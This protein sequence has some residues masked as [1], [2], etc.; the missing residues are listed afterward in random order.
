[1]QKFLL[2]LSLFL[3]ILLLVYIFY[4]SRLAEKGYFFI[5]ELKNLMNQSKTMR[6]SMRELQQPNNA[7]ITESYA[8]I[9]ETSDIKEENPDTNDNLETL[10]KK[11][12]TRIQQQLNDAE[13]KELLEALAQKQLSIK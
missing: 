10:F 5:Q 3:N 6:M 1:M 9:K 7:N 2:K 13:L 11:T 12:N 8:D 4:Y